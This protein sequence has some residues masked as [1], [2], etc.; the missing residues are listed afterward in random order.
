MDRKGAALALGCVG[1][2]IMERL[3]MVNRD[4]AGRKVNHNFFA[5]VHGTAA[6]Q[7]GTRN[8]YSRNIY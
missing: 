5:G 6:V 1:L 2:G 8:I 4:T 7:Q 3:A